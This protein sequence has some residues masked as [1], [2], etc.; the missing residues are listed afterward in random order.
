MDSGTAGILRDKL[1]RERK[2]QLGT[3]GRLGKPWGI[4]DLLLEPFAHALYNRHGVD[5][6][7]YRGHWTC[8]NPVSQW[9]LQA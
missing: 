2:M 4:S 3:Q 1:E 7:P 8:A 5:F 6:L 9:P